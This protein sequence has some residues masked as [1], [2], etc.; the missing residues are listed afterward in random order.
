MNSHSLF[1]KY[2]IMAHNDS[3][4]ELSEAPT[5]A[6]NLFSIAAGSI[7]SSSKIESLYK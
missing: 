3:D 7:A 6:T 1:D 4:S 2:I 5:I